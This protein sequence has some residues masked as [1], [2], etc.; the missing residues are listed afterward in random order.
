MQIYNY[1]Q[2]ALLF[3]NG[4]LISRL[5]IKCGIA[6]KM[7]FFFIQKSKGHLS[8]ILIYITFSTAFLS[9][10]IPNVVA[11]LAIL[12]LLEILQKDLN[13][14]YTN[15]KTELN[16]PLALSSLYGANIGGT[17]SISGSPASLILI[18][19]LIAHKIPSVEKLNFFSWLGWGF[20]LVVIFSGLSVLVLIYTS[21]PKKIRSAKINFVQ[22]HQHK[23]HY[24]HEKTAI[25]LSISSFIFWLLI[26]ALNLLIKKWFLYTTILA[27]LFNIAF[28]LVTFF[29]KIKDSSDPLNP[30]K[31]SLILTF[32]DCYSNLPAKGFII[33]IITVAVSLLL[34]YLK[35]DRFLVGFTKGFLPQ[36][37]SLFWVCFI[38]CLFTVYISE[39]ISNTASAVSFF[40]IAEAICVSLNLPALPVLLGISVVS[41]VPSM[42]P[43]ASPVNAMLFGGIKGVKLKKMIL[44]GILIN[45]IG[46][47]LISFWSAYIIPYYYNL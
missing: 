29:I 37:G 30:R 36:T 17:G 3:A 39:F 47:F 7:V 38:F 34:V 12:P 27:F 35:V 5:F 6:E 19:F 1:I 20:P 10:F 33:L 21:I 25:W 14:I 16:T 9:M 43:L 44:V 23:K 41:T 22:I 45:I 46:V 2:L 18:G 28:V 40:I 8:K 13:Y 31:K 11:I 15:D 4:F 42:S 24:L 26:S 32:K